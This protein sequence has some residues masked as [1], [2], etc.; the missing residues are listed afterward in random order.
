MWWNWLGTCFKRITT[1]DHDKSKQLPRMH[2]SLGI[3][4]GCGVV[5]ANTGRYDWIRREAL[6]EL[7]NRE[8]VVM[9]ERIVNNSGLYDWIRKMALEGLKKIK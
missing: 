4:S 7:I 1:D 3:Y 5:G 2:G 6:Q 8:V 9:L